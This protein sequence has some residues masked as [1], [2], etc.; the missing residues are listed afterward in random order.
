VL[1]IAALKAGNSATASSSTS[2]GHM[3]DVTVSCG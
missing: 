1:L 2:A 3:H